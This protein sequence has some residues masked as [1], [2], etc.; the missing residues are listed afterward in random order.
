M[1]V[2]CALG[3]HKWEGCKCLKCEKSRDQTHDWSRDC[4]KCAKCG[5][6]RQITHAWEGCTC[7]NCARE[8]H[9]WEGALCKI[10]GGPPAFHETRMCLFS[11]TEVF[12]VEAWFS[13][14]QDFKSWFNNNKYVFDTRWVDSGNVICGGN[15]EVCHFH[16]V[17][18][19]LLMKNEGIP[20]AEVRSLMPQ[21]IELREA[22]LATD[23]QKEFLEFCRLA[24]A[25][26]ST[27]SIFLEEK[28]CGPFENWFV[29]CK[30]CGT[31]NARC[32]AQS[33]SVFAER[34]IRQSG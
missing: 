26:S 10:C 8:R 31:V 12:S 19:T 5:K 24:C 32:V 28:N 13:S 34:M 18:K 21:S 6:G 9:E 3:F 1:N 7:S 27:H 4:D 22:G 30:V 2:T 29:R 25:S 33:T 14:V 23:V 15:E 20:F 17:K 16:D 11:E